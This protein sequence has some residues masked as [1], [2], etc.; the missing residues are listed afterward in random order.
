MALQVGS[1]HI[2][3][4]RAIPVFDEV[5]LEHPYLWIVLLYLAESRLVFRARLKK[6]KQYPRVIPDRIMEGDPRPHLLIL[7]VVL[8]NQETSDLIKGPTGN[9]HSA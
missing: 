3:I 8:A 7:T 2:S 1:D 5:S 9:H 6:G 4:S